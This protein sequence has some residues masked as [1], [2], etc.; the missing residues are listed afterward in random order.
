MGLG[1]VSLDTFVYEM[2]LLLMTDSP[3]FDMSLNTYCSKH[4]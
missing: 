1:F 3:Q 4:N 2:L